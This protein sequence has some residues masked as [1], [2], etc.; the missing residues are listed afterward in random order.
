M[1]LG[2]SVTDAVKYDSSCRPANCIAENFLVDKEIP[3]RTKL[4]LT[5]IRIFLFVG[6]KPAEFDSSWFSITFTKTG[7]T[8]LCKVVPKKKKK[9]GRSL[10]IMIQNNDF[11]KYNSFSYEL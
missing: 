2:V 10:D 3:P 6:L 9:N 11:R 7:A 1:F 8:F 4:L 5:E